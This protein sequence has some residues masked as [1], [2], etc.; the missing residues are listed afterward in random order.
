MASNRSAGTSDQVA[1]AFDRRSGSDTGAEVRVVRELR[2]DRALVERL[3]RKARANRW[4]LPI[5][6]F[7]VALEAS[8]RKAFAS[9]SAPAEG[10]QIERYLDALHLDDLALACACAEGSEP[11]WEYFI[12]EHRPGLYRAAAAIDASG[13]SRDLADSLYG[14]LFGLDVR[15][16]ERRS[17]FRY[18]HGR[19]SLATWLRAVLSQRHV[20]RLRTVRRLDPL[21]EDESPG[22]IAAPGEDVDP[23]RERYVSLMR[24]AVTAAVAALASRDRLRLRCYYAQHLTLAQIGRLLDE[25]EATASRHLGRARRDIR[26]AVE[27][28]L[29]RQGMSDAEMATCFAIIVSDSA[30]LD[31]AELLG[32]DPGSDS[33]RTERKKGEVERSKSKE[34]SRAGQR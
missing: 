25:S 4:S 23:N 16:G 13:S 8:A 29:R 6:A 12:R 1:S 9:A 27:A 20:D 22:A 17:H 21:P 31:L 5:E 15:D 32:S 34:R 26:A 11:A 3:H 7:A 24:D 14:E 33:N 28:D 18:F 19:S 2:L 10:P 30:Y